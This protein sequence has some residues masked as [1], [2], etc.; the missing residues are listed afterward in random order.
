MPLIRA[1]RDADIPALAALYGHYVETALATFETDPPDAAEL[2]R[3]RQDVLAYGLPYVVAEADGVLAGYAYATVYRPRPAY[4]FTVE[5]SVYVHPA[6]AGQGLGRLLLG[7]VIAACAAAGRRQMIAVIGDSDNVAS[8]GL[9]RAL[10]FQYVGVLR[11]VGFKFD[12]W[13]DTVL[14][15]RGL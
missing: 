4:R 10:G 5:D 14:M 8:I 9:H 2:A 13:V 7:Q 6:Y 11:D 12:R 3:R 1:A 15:Q